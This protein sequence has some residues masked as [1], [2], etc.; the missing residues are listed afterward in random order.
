[1]KTQKIALMLCAAILA[2]GITGCK[3]KQVAAAP[4]PT[5]PAKAPVQTER[6]PAAVINSFRADPSTVI[7]GESTTLSWSVSNATEVSIDNG[8]GVVPATGSRQVSPT[9]GIT[10]RM[11]AKGLG[12]DAVAAVTVNVTSAP[13][14]PP[15]PP[16]EKPSLSERMAREIQDVYFDYDKSEVREDARAT[17]Q[18]NGDAMKAI[19]NDFPSA[20][21]TV[22][23][24]CDERGS[25]EYNLGLGDRRANSVKEF[26][27][28][29]GVPDERLKPLSYGKERPICTDANESCWQKNRRAHFQAVQ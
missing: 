26:L 21:I 6:G 2:A 13:A 23:G 20:V 22:E 1:M 28:Q 14:P 12:G 17:L 15:P 10:Y 5:P 25:A 4:P 24:H 16:K 18:R 29:I 8:I 9:Q 19:L 27:V 7:R 11:L 3:K